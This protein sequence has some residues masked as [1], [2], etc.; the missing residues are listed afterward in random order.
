MLEFLMINVI[1]ILLMVCADI[2]RIQIIAGSVV[3]VGL[4][5]YSC[6]GDE[7]SI[8]EDFLIGVHHR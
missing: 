2:I 3:V 4:G 6:W 5:S 1:M 8:L 7:K